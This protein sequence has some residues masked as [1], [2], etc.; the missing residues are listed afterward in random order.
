MCCI[1]CFPYN[2]NKSLSSLAPPQWETVNL[3]ADAID[4]RDYHVVGGVFQFDLL[5]LPRQ[6]RTGRG[7]HWTNRVEPAVLAPLEYT[8]DIQ[9]EKCNAKEVIADSHLHEGSEQEEDQPVK[10]NDELK[11]DKQISE[12]TIGPPVY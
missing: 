8:V 9:A 7:W 1:F 6:P 12:G 2:F 3:P 5:K 11:I 10:V 4:L